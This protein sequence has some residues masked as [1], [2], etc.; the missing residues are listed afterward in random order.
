MD[1]D[2]ISDAWGIGVEEVRDED[3]KH[4]DN[5]VLHDYPDFNEDDNFN[6]ED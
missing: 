2:G 1:N 3:L 4:K 6:K 5:G